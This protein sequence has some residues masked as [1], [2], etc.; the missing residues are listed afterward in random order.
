MG[1]LREGVGPARSICTKRT[2]QVRGAAARSSGAEPRAKLS[3]ALACPPP[4]FPPRSEASSPLSFAAL[5]SRGGPVTPVAGRR[6]GRGAP[7]FRFPGVTRALPSAPGSH[8]VRVAT[9]SVEDPCGTPGRA[10]SPFSVHGRV[11]LRGWLTAEGESGRVSGFHGRSLVTRATSFQLCLLGA[12][13]T[14][15]NLHNFK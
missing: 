3:R 15:V 10:D 6:A 4:A 12:R 13:E 2:K 11:D 14:R 8:T 9:S 1:V 7:P 5:N